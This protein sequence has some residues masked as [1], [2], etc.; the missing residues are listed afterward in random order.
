MNYSN[1][2]IS[3]LGGLVDL[4]PQEPSLQKFGYKPLP[5]TNLTLK[6]G[7][8]NQNSN[9]NIEQHWNNVGSHI[10]NAIDKFYEQE[11]SNEKK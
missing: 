3:G 2:L 11:L 4:F 10:R 1:M 9:G 8:I 6:Q 5:V 7:E